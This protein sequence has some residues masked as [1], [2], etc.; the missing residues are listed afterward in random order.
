MRSIDVISGQY[1]LHYLRLHLTIY[2]IQDT[3]Y[4]TICPTAL[5]GIIHMRH[6]R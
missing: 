5:M 1:G 6:I 4:D 3:F 2:V